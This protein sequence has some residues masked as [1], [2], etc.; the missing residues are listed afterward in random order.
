MHF[1]VENEIVVVVEVELG[2]RRME[3]VKFISIAA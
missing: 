1:G 2:A 3:R